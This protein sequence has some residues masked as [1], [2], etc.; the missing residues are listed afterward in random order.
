MDDFIFIEALEAQMQA[1]GDKTALVF[2]GKETSYAQLSSLSNK[3]ANAL[4]KDGVKPRSRVAFMGNN[5][6]IYFELLLGVQK[7]RAALV[8]VNS[9]LAPPE[10]AFVINDAQAEMIFVDRNYAPLIEK[11]I[12]DCPNVRRVI[13]MDFD[14]ADWTGFADWRDAQSDAHPGGDYHPDDDIIQLYTSGTTGHPKGVQ[15][16]N[17]NMGGA[18]HQASIDWGGWVSDDHVLLCMPLFHIA[19]VNV[20]LIGLNA[21]ATVTVLPA[22][23]PAEILRLIEETKV[24]I[25]FMVPAVIL[26]VM[27]EDESKS[28]DISSVRQ[29][30]YGA[31]PIAE[32]LLVSA[33]QTFKCDFIQVYGLTETT[34]CATHLPA[35]DHAA[36]RGKLRSCGKP[37]TGVE[38]KIVDENNHEVP[39]GQ[40]GEILI[41]AA[42]NM[43]GYWN[44]PDATSGAVKD[45][46]FYSGDAG[47]TDDEGY[48]FIH[49]RVKDMIV[50]GGENVY[51][52]EVENALFSHPDIA[53][54]AVIGVPDEKWGEAVKACVVLRPDATLSQEDIIAFARELVAGYKLPKS[55]DFVEA[56]PRNPSGKILRRELREPYWE[57]QERRVG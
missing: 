52:A 51:P 29:V 25:L 38:I 15:L 1:Q 7:T 30:V 4:I 40:V 21:G 23:N 31:S 42:T 28:R 5:S 3:V 54:V 2:K 50:S 17:S 8:G 34:G 20:G 41:K 24:T 57:G 39:V 47:Y 11:I 44:N 53:D 36:E 6:A 45:G 12:D 13:A 16:T 33:Q 55:V 26:F 49:D 9:R 22:V 27:Q 14:H 37:N 10:V 56:L 48:I 19:G 43:K 35:A 32:D 18:L 46:W